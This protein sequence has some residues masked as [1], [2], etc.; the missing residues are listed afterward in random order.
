MVRQSQDP[1]SE[2][3]RENVFDLVDAGKVSC[4]MARTSVIQKFERKIAT[5]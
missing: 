5:L 3:D 1:T 4:L 2:E